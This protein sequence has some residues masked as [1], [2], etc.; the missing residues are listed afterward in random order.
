MDKDEKLDYWTFYIFKL[1]M[2]T[3][4]IENQFRSECRYYIK[5]ERK[6][7]EIYEKFEMRLE[8]FKQYKINTKQPNKTDLWVRFEVIKF[9]YRAIMSIAHEYKLKNIVLYCEL[10]KD[11]LELDYVFLINHA[12]GRKIYDS[13]IRRIKKYV[14]EFTN[15]DFERLAQHAWPHLSLEVD[16]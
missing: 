11:E 10:Q 3:K 1:M 8:S 2:Q 5:P 13:K 14:K 9:C 16:Y 7:N 4:E 12:L 6:K 15:L